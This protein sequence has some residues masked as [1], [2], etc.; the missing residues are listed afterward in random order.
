MPAGI[1]RDV[2]NAAADGGSE[3]LVGVVRVQFAGVELSLQKL[4]L[5]C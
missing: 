5:R 2:A 3:F 1:Q 4:L